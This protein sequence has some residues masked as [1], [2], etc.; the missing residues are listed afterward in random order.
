MKMSRENDSKFINLEKDAQGDV[1][2]ADEVVAVIAG[3]SALEV[4]GVS[5]MAGNITMSVIGRVGMKTLSKGIRIHVDEETGEVRIDLA[6]T[7]KYGHSIPD[8]CKGIQE[9]VKTNVETMT[10]LKISDV[11]IRIAGMAMADQVG[12]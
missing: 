5:A 11:N 10:P 7:V 8:I 1:K 6:V 3:Y 2:I 4:E 9:K 12:I